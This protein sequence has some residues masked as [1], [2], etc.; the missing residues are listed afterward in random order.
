MLRIEKKCVRYG[1][2]TAL[3][4][5]TKRKRNMHKNGRKL[6]N[7]IS[8]AKHIFKGTRIINARIFFYLF[9]RC[10]EIMTHRDKKLHKNNSLLGSPTTYNFQNHVLF[11]RSHAYNNK[12]NRNSF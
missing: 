10:Q 6:L 4:L 11:F 5:T 7:N 1:G 8:D 9:T 3:Y 2:F 12:K